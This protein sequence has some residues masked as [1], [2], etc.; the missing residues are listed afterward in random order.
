MGDDRKHQGRRRPA[1]KPRHHHRTPHPLRIA[2][3]GRRPPFVRRSL[4]FISREG[5]EV[6]EEAI[7]QGDR[8]DEQGGGGGEGGG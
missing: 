8:F 2:A 1:L 6:A 7:R 4:R 3:R 5:Q